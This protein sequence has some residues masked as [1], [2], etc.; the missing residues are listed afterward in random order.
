MGNLRKGKFYE[1]NR[2]TGELLQVTQQ[3]TSTH[4]FQ[5]ENRCTTTQIAC[6]QKYS[7]SSDKIDFGIQQKTSFG[8]LNDVQKRYKILF[9]CVMLSRW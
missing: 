1:C 8:V 7:F 9:T 3:Q 5:V 6:C 2:K 4:T